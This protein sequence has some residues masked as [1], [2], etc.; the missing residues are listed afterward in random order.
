MI[1]SLRVMNSL[2]G[3]MIGKKMRMGTAAAH[4][5]AGIAENLKAFVLTVDHHTD[6][7]D[8]DN[9]LKVLEAQDLFSNLVYFRGWTTPNLAALQKGKH[10]LGNVGDVYQRIENHLVVYQCG[11]DILFID[12]WHCYAYA[13]ED[14]ETYRPLLSSPA[15]I[16]C[17][18]IQ[19]GGGPESPIQGMMQF[20]EEMPEPKFLN[21]NLH[22]GTNMGFVKV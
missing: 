14:L 15:L 8:D 12:S 11:I 1:H 21:A 19:A 2:I 10:A 22:P 4:F 7:G 5:A 18:D 20:W 17:D 13:K 6:L 9:Q 16:I 3:V